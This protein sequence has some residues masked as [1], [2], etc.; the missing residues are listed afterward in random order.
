[1]RNWKNG[2]GHY[3]VTLV[4]TLFALSLIVI[5]SFNSFYTLAK[6]DAITIGDTAVNERAKTLNNFYMQSFEAI[7]I[8]E[9]MVDYMMHHG[10]DA[11]EI[12]EYLVDA[13]EEY[14][15]QINENFTGIYGWIEDT[16]IDGVG[17]IPGA[18]YVATERVWYTDAMEKGGEAALVSPYI[19]AQT[20]QVI[21][22]LSKML[23]DGKSVISLDRT[24]DDIQ[25]IAEEIN[26]NGNGYGFVMDKAGMVVAHSDKNQ[27]GNNYL[28]DEAFQ[29]SDMNIVVQNIMQGSGEN[30][31]MVIDGKKSMVFSEKLEHD[32]YVVM[33]IN[34]ADLFAKVE[35]VLFINII[36]SLLVFGMVAYF[37]TASH[38]HKMKSMHYAEELKEYQRTLEDRVLEQTKEIRKQSEEMIRMQEDVIEGMATLIESRD[39]NTGEHVKNTK[40]YVSLIV[41]K[42]YEKKMH[43]D[44]VGSSYVNKLINAAALH[45]VGKIKIS[46]LILNK[47]ARL[48]KEEFEIMKTHSTKGGEI[49]HSILGD[50]ADEEMVEI[51][52]DVARYHHERWDGNG[53]PTGLKE[54][55]IPLAARIM[56]VADVFDA[57]ISKRVYKDRI[58]VEKAFS[59]IEEESGKQFDPEVVELFVESKAEIWDYLE[60]NK[61]VF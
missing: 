56:A 25:V 12:E 32:W 49:V 48:D 35:R 22:S 54:E 10:H 51:A 61:I 9:Q 19:D 1:M 17:W 30:F 55:E 33:I 34:S 40:W 13:S 11:R 59:M 3:I 8:T 43:E 60:E 27:R 4:G 47:P 45:D 31:K 36:L 58:P 29:G 6:E 39:E 18:D 26:L 57:L 2:R 42:M 14:S 50:H 5:Y 15:T 37:C 20:N 23:S 46:D 28:T 53:Y 52:G 38:Y 24:L 44:I 41:K 21:I 7:N 16:Y